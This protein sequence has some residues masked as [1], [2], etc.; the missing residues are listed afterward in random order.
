MRP[1]FLVDRVADGGHR[2]AR[3]E[4]QHRVASD[5]DTHLAADVGLPLGDASVGGPS[6]D[7]TVVVAGMPAPLAA[8]EAGHVLQHFGMTGREFVDLLHHRHRAG[9]RE[10]HRAG[11]EGRRGAGLI[12]APAR[13]WAAGGRPAVRVLAQ[14]CTRKPARL[15]PHRREQKPS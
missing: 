6:L 7:E 12:A 4:Q 1:V 13:A 10:G 11:P 2:R 5:I 15:R 8:A 3:V 9:R 14:G